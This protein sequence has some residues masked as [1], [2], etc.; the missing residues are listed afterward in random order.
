MYIT[1]GTVLYCA[2]ENISTTQ[3]RTLPLAMYINAHFAVAIVRYLLLLHTFSV[4]KD[5][6]KSSCKQGSYSI[7]D[8]GGIHPA[9]CIPTEGGPSLQKLTQF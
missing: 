5:E 6:I 7:H 8:N 3:Y 4:K 2:V 9:F 1:R